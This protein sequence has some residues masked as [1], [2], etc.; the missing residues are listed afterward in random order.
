MLPERYQKIKKYE[1][2]IADARARY[3]N[4]IESSIFSTKKLI[5]NSKKISADLSAGMM[6]HIL[7]EKDDEKYLQE[8]RIKV[9]PKRSR[10]M[11]R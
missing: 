2:I 7:N 11:I 1:E 6:K 3:H 4:H 8:Y 10:S 9:P 5:S